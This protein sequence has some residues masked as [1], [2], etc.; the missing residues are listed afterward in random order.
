MLNGIYKEI[1]ERILKTIKSI[2]CVFYILI[3]EYTNWACNLS[4]APCVTPLYELYIQFFTVACWES[5]LPTGGLSLRKANGCC[6]RRE[7]SLLFTFP[8]KTLP[9]RTQRCNLRSH[10]CFYLEYCDG[11]HLWL[12]ADIWYVWLRTW[13]EL[14]AN[15]ICPKCF[16]VG[17]KPWREGRGAVYSL[18]LNGNTFRSRCDWQYSYHVHRSTCKMWSDYQVKNVHLP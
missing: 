1:T 6:W 5:P 2:L 18:D 9:V 12:T 10:A 11:I 14:F 4:A 17:G 15:T 7:R 13:Q 8:T 3:L 16:L